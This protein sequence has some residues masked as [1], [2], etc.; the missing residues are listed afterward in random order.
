MHIGVTRLELVTSW[1]PSRH[2]TKLSYTPFVYIIPAQAGC[3]KHVRC[4]ASTSAST[5]PS[6]AQRSPTAHMPAR[7]YRIHRIVIAVEVRVLV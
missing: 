1:P 7:I 5:Y 6:P 3:V 2:S 4:L